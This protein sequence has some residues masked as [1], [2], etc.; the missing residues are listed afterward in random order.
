MRGVIEKS[1]LL[2]VAKA[3]MQLWECRR[4]CLCGDLA[5]RD[6]NMKL[7]S[8][9]CVF[10]ISIGAG[11]DMYSAVKAEKDGLKRTRQRLALLVHPDKANGSELSRYKAVFDSAFK[12]L[13][14]A[15]DTLTAAAEGRY[16]ECGGVGGAG[17]G[18]GAAP[19]QPYQQPQYAGYAAA[20][21]FPGGGFGGFPW[22][23]PGYNP[24]YT[25][26]GAAYW[27]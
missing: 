21:G 2:R 26:A 13:T 10:R 18:A 23:F 20:G 4:I 19:R 25:Q 12:C 14:A 15:H 22:G 5:A 27:G 6:A 8:A 9:V 24:S 7:Y 11:Q 17:A 1:D 16:E 3:H